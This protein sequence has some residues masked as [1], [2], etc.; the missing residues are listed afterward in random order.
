MK[1]NQIL[2]LNNKYC[3]F[4]RMVNIFF[5]KI[6]P[7]DRIVKYKIA[8]WDKFPTSVEEAKTMGSE[9]AKKF[10]LSNTYTNFLIG[11]Y[12][13]LSSKTIRFELKQKKCVIRFELKQKKCVIKLEQVDD[14]KK[15]IIN[16]LF[17]RK[18]SYF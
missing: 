8:R 15:N 12:F 9:W 7:M 10:K 17:I 2:I 4:E 5:H 13:N 3:D 11:I 6:K 14:V 18:N 16:N 1:L